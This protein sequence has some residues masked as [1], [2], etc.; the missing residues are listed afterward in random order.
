MGTKGSRRFLVTIGAMYPPVSCDQRQ[1]FPVCL[2]DLVD[3]GDG[4]QIAGS[5][6]GRPKVDRAVDFIILDCLVLQDMLNCS[7]RVDLH[8]FVLPSFQKIF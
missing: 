6:A 5:M 3:L 1:M 7:L 4:D 2:D 8:F